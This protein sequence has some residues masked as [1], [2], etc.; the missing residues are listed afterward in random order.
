MAKVDEELLRKLK[1]AEEAYDPKKARRI[2]ES[3]PTFDLTDKL[4][5]SIRKRASQPEEQ[6]DGAS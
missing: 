5:I 3:L 4:A 6:E 1:A 2:R